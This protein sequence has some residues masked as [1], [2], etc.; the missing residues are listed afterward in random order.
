FWVMGLSG[1]TRIQIFP[2]RFTRRVITR[3]AASIWRAVRRPRSTAFR[4]NSPKLTLLP[5]SASP[6][7]RPLCCFLNFVRFGC[8]IRFYPTIPS[9]LGKF[10]AFAAKNLALEDPNLDANDPVGGRRFGS[11]V[12]DIRAQRVQG[13]TAF[14]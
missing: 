9:F 5:R 14:P 8:S 13:N 4:P 2:P 10:G 12:I 7:F 3:R 11:A 6:R 1:N